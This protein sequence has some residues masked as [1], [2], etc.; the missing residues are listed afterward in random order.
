MASAVDR[1]GL[2]AQCS[3]FE[4]AGLGGFHVIPIY[5]AKGYEDK[6]RRYLSAEWMQAFKE[7]VE[8][9][10]RHGL[11]VDMTMGS[12]WCFGGSN[13]K[14]EEGCWKFDVVKDLKPPYLHWF[15][16]GQQVKRAGPGGAGPMMDPFSKAA[17]RSFLEPFKVF[18][19][20]GAARP[21]HVYHDSWEYYCAEWSPELFAAFKAKRGYALEDHLRE[22]AGK[23]TK[24]EVSR[25]RLDY[26]ETLSDIVI[27]DTFPIWVKW[28]HDRGIKVRN[29][30]HGSMANWLDFYALADMP[31]TE[32]Y[33]A[34]A[35]ILVSKFASSAAH[36][37]GKRFV[38]SES[39]TWVGQHFGE[40]LSDLKRIIDRLF[41]SG[42]NHMY[43]HGCCY[44]PVDAIWPGWC[45]YAGAEV[46]PRNPVWRDIKY[47]NAYI[48]RCQAMFQ[49]AEP[50]EDT[51]VYWPLRDY[52]Y[53]N[54]AT[55]ATP[56]SV[57]RRDWFYGMPVGRIAL[58][59]QREGY[60]FDY[61]SDRM[62]QKGV[63]AR[64]TNLVVPECRHMPEATRRAIDRFRARGS[65]TEPFP[66]SGVLFTRM[67]RGDETL[68]Y[69]VNTNCEK[70]VVAANPSA[71]GSKWWMDPMTGDISPAGDTLALEGYASGFL[72]VKASG[73][74]VAV[75]APVLSEAVCLAGPWRLAPVCGG[76]ELPEPRTMEALTTWSRN[77]DGSENPFCGTMRYETTFGWSGAVDGVAVLDLGRVEQSARVR[78]NGRDVGFSFMAPHRV[79][80]AASILKRG[81]NHLEVE[82]TSLGQN[83]IRWYG[84]T[85]VNW[86]YFYDANVEDYR[87]LGSSIGDIPGFD[88]ATLP[89]LDC[90]LLGS[91]TLRNIFDRKTTEVEKRKERR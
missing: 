7:A 16:T 33:S 5:G 74:A 22:L 2:E 9:A 10:G 54:Q 29:E 49:A 48:A 27:E 34:D 59:L 79:R 28:A 83:R 78:V 18:D 68:Y 11:G 21:V 76:P 53:E 47:L 63:P 81:E 90:G 26:R 57:H 82:V 84:Q 25:V 66:K 45:F 24:E 65:R 12:G 6:A 73:M 55:I 46:N 3:A 87:K 23:G 85:G 32:M 71:R 60:A 14:K 80:F 30:A 51:L 19:E 31:E 43:Y 39:C 56:M 8:I 88:T 72:V 44:S 69:L 86:M 38:S 4:E 64:Y 15:P 52:W 40:K 17:M 58:R 67:R 50:D 13:L 1:E 37:T 41:L 91:V 36:V 35:D 62:L 89:L 20:P 70:V 75:Q 77:A 61:V 42:V